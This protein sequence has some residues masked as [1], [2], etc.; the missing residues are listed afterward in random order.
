MLSVTR[1]APTPGGVGN[2]AGRGTGRRVWS[3]GGRTTTPARGRPRGEPASSKDA[4]SGDGAV[5]DS[6]ERVVVSGEAKCALVSSEKG[7]YTVRGE[8]TLVGADASSVYNLLTDYEASPRAFRAVR[9]VK[10]VDCE[11]NECVASNIYI[12]QECEWKFFVFGGAFPCSFEVEE[13]DE[14]KRM[15]CSLA[16]NAKGRGFLRQFEGSW[17]VEETSDG[18]RVEHTL[19]VQPKLTPPYASK[20]FVQQ[21]EQIM[22]DVANEIASWNGA[23]YDAPPHRQPVAAEQ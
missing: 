3:R 17:V 21:V 1:R 18:V 14:E 5:G 15:K 23:R 9:S 20:I 8:M 16:P 12:E 4:Q 6:G 19:M 2:D 11:G 22:E 7:A 10:V 13:R